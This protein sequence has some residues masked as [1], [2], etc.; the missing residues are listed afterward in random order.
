MPVNPWVLIK[1]PAIMKIFSK[2]ILS[3]AGA[4]SQ[5]RQQIDGVGME[6][7]NVLFSQPWQF[8]V[9]PNGKQEVQ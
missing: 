9:G 4:S 2:Y 7:K 3:W 6:S 5:Y 8:F 1:Y